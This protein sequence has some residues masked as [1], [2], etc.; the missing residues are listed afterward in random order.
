MTT[1]VQKGQKPSV[2]QE[3]PLSRVVADPE[4]NARHV[5]RYATKSSGDDEHGSTILNLAAGIKH[6]GQ[7]Q[8]VLVTSQGQLINGF[9]RFAALSKIAEAKES[10]PGLPD[11]HIRVQIVPD[12]SNYRLASLACDVNRGELV[13]AD[14]IFGIRELG[15]QVTPEQIQVSLG[16]GQPYQSRLTNIAK[17]I[18]KEE[19]QAW[20]ESRASIPYSFIEGILKEGIDASERVGKIKNYSPSKRGPKNAAT[21]GSSN[22]TGG[23][24]AIDERDP[25]T[26]VRGIK[27]TRTLETFVDGLAKLGV[28]QSWPHEATQLLLTL[29]GSKKA[30][31]LTVQE[32]QA[33]TDL[34]AGEVRKISK[35]K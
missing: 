14:L 6:E 22:G 33:Y 5:N 2:V 1:Q 24:N 25:L 20:R 31:A 30:E 23:E 12:G 3:W 29:V 34:V 15:E 19:M 35:K 16:I 32:R 8:P 11:G 18:T 27:E 4:W 17:K 9:R 28:I 26:V 13:P 21:N 10:V 7:L